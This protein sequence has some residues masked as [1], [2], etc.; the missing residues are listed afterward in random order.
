MRA[1][2]AFVIAA[3][4]AT[5]L[6]LVDHGGSVAIVTHPRHEVLEACAAGRGERV[7]GIA[8]AVEMQTGRPNRCHDVR[9]FDC[10][11]RQ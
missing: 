11:A 7:S 1:S 4:G 5:S 9:P 3:S 6:V 2:I 8:Q 10:P